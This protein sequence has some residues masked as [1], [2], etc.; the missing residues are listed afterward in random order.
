MNLSSNF[1]S[2]SAHLKPFAGNFLDIS[3]Q[4]KLFAS[5]YIR[6]DDSMLL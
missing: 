4:Y 6:Y 5:K 1:D 2:F 3:H